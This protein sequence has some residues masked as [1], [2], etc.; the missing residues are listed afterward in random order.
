MKQLI[1]LFLM[2]LSS[3]AW[4]TYIDFSFVG[5]GMVIDVSGYDQPEKW[6]LEYDQIIDLTGTFR[7]DTDLMVLDP[8]SGVKFEGDFVTEALF[9]FDGNILSVDSGG[10]GWVNIYSWP[11]VIEIYWNVPLIAADGEEFTHIMGGNGLL[12][13]TDVSEDFWT[14]NPDPLGTLFAGTTQL[15]SFGTC[16][17][18]QGET[19]YIAIGPASGEV[20]SI[21]SPVPE[22]TSLIIFGAGLVGIVGLK[23]RKRLLH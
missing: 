8:S 14:E 17:L 19:I 18:L 13:Y 11:N 4:G 16:P 3:P 22:P 1:V 6:D 21:P 5:S 9:S 20:S 23:S 15:S 12:W 2:L 7:F 10:S